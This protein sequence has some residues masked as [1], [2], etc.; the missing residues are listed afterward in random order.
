MV[1]GPVPKEYVPGVEKGL[2]AE[3]RAVLL[4]GSPLIDFKATLGRRQIS[5][6]RTPTR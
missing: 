6:S 1:G 3:E 5:R 4:A 2:N